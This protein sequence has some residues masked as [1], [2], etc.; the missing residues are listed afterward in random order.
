MTCEARKLQALVLAMLRETG[1]APRTF[2]AQVLLE[3]DLLHFEA[4]NE[5]LS[6]GIYE[7]H[8]AGPVPRG[9]DVVLAEAVIGEILVC[10]REE[11]GTRV[12]RSGAHFALKLA[13]LQ[14]ALA[15]EEMDS[16]HAALGT[17]RARN[18]QEGR[19]RGHL[20]PAWRWGG[21]GSL[22]SVA[23]LACTSE[24][25]LFALADRCWDASDLTEDR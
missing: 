7:R 11:D 14:D 24:E 20:L 19:R 16:L 17:V 9:L 8:A 25:E 12:F 23:A 13:E 6:G 3:A 2:L 21:A 10:R 5:A 15:P 18:A 1:E 22:L 4:W